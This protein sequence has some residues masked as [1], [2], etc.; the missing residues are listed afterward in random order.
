MTMDLPAKK[1]KSLFPIS[2][3]PVL[4]GVCSG[5]YVIVGRDRRTTNT[6]GLRSSEKPLDA[7]HHGRQAASTPPARFAL[8]NTP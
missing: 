7:D 1:G 8:K 4:P 6:R 3:E 2:L 5:R